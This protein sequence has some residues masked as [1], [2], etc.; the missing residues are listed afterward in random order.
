MADRQL[1]EE[2]IFE[3]AVEISSHDARQ[4]YLEQACGDD[5]DLK[6]RLRTLLRVDGIQEPEET[7][8]Q[9]ADSS[10]DFPTSIGPYKL[11]QKLGE[12]GMGVVY[13][14]EQKKPLVRRVALKVIKPGM[15]T[16]QVIA[17]FEAE[18][19]ALAMMDHPN[20]AK[21]LDAGQTESGQPYFVMELVNGIPITKFCDEQRLTPKE[22]LELFVPVCQ[23]V[24]HAHQKGVI[25]RD[26][27]PGNILIALYDSKP[28]PKIIDFGVAKATS[29][30]LTEKTMYTQLGQVIG[31]LEYMSP[32]QSQRNQLDID[33]R[34]DVYSLGVVLYELLTG[35]LPMDRQRLRTAGYEEIMRII[36]EVEPAKPSTRVSSSAALPSIAANRRVEPKR[37]A[38][39]VRGELDWIVMKALDKERGRRYETANAFAVD[40]QR[41]SGRRTSRSR[42]SLGRLSAQKIRA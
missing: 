10:G 32:E 21:V 18:R 15:D 14:A 31:T 13:M 20:I 37:L 28:I 9:V 5:D 23:G 11:L 4:A 19:Q 6:A 22:R 29:Q 2:E 25:H 1:S 42:P 17:R 26:L 12:G 33:T 39:L 24:Q 16:R 27:K 35:E 41:V 38:S 7:S 30:S 36:R 34:T 40:L 8:L 3:I